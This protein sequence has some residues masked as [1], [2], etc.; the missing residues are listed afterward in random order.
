MGKSNTPAVFNLTIYVNYLTAG[1]LYARQSER[2]VLLTTLLTLLFL[3][4]EITELLTFT[5]TYESTLLLFL[6]TMSFSSRSYRKAYSL[7]LLSVILVLG[8]LSTLFI[9]ASDISHD[10]LPLNRERR[11]LI[12]SSLLIIVLAK[13]PTYPLHF[14]LP[15]AHV[16][17]TWIGSTLLAC[18]LLKFS[19]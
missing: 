19:T 17:S 10:W 12:L 6:P 15:E 3:A 4:T 2:L 8:T 11:S 14:W 5:V 16:E 13:T 18:I 9:L 7:L 1:A